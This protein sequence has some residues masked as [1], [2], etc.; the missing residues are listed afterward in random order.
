MIIPDKN[1]LKINPNCN[2]YLIIVDNNKTN[3]NSIQKYEHCLYMKLNVDIPIT[4]DW[5]T[6]YLNWEK[7]F[8][9]IENNT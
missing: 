3:N 7:I 6:T 1:L 5:T 2:F 8:F 4:F 9:D